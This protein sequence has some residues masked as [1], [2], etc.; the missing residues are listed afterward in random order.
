M[1]GRVDPSLAT[2]VQRSHPS[3]GRSEATDPH[4]PKVYLSCSNITRDRTQDPCLRR[5]AEFAHAKLLAPI[6]VVWRNFWRTG[7]SAAHARTGWNS[8][9][10]SRSIP[11]R[12]VPL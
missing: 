8:S 3:R 12:S 2:N 6:L 5:Q 7:S 11:R 4:E 10:D 9:L 1:K